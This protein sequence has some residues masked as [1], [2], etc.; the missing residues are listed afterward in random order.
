M[1]FPPGKLPLD[2][3]SGLL[4][5]HTGADD[6]VLIGARVGEDAA[7]ISFGD[8][9]LVAKTDPITFATDEIGHYAIH[10][11]ANDIA[12]MGAEPRWFLATVL[13]PE[14]Q[15][16]ETLVER[17]LASVS[18][19]A[20]SIGVSFCGGHTE[21]TAG[22]DRPIVVGQMLGEVGR[23]DIVRSSGLSE[24]DAVLLTKGL[25]IEATSLIA[26]EKRGA[27]SELGLDP[28]CLETAANY[29]HDPG[30][31]VLK[32]ARIACDTARVHAMHDP[33]EGGVATALREMAMA[34]ET[35]LLVDPDGLFMSDL[36]R[37]LCAAF[38]LDPLGVISSGALL[39]GLAEKDAGR[40]RVAIQ[41]AGIACEVVARV[42][43][44]GAGIWMQGD[45][46]PVDLPAF[47]RDEIGKIF[48]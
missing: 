38:N 15:T 29:L 48:A 8:T 13:L 46:G 21:V 43:T 33:T 20:E 6:R 17:V 16:D 26:R 4:N 25:G 3:L 22:L 32:E 19:A 23:D 12:T 42:T 37:Q 5:R 34:A 31:S 1:I 9:C 14:G 45:K 47:D 41:A 27:L 28:E 10:V 40:V 7:V 39:I 2:V 30:I 11:N 44:R 24:G 36:T 35:G 18:G